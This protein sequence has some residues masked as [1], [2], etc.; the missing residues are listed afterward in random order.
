MSNH[1][2]LD[3][4]CQVCTLCYRPI[5][6]QVW[7]SG[8]FSFEE[9]DGR[10]TDW[11]SKCEIPQFMIQNTFSSIL[12]ITLKTGIFSSILINYLFYIFIYC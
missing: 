5:C 12:R 9:A 10:T 8:K 4:Y 2:G 6:D 7:Q 11:G 3:G 1:P